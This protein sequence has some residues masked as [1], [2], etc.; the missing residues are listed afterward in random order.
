MSVTAGKVRVTSAV[1][2]ASIKVAL[3]VPLSLSSKNSIKPAEVAPFFTCKLALNATTPPE[4]IDIASVSDAEP[5]VTTVCNFDTTSSR[6]NL[7]VPPVVIATSSAALKN[8][9]VFVS[10][11][12]VIDGADA[13][14]SANDATPV[15]DGPAE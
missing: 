13:L 8:T 4:E 10:P 11:V 3:F 15:I 2:A 14:P 5:I 7:C 12:F 9:P 1:D 6:L